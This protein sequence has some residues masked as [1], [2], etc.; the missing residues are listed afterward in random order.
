M[1]LL[2]VRHGESEANAAGVVA[3]GGK[4]A[5]S[6][7]GIEQAQKTGE[8]LV[9]HDIKVIA[10]SPYLRAQQTA[11]IIAGEIGIG[12]KDIKI[13]EELRERD[14]GETEGKPKQHD[15]E[16]YFE[17]DT[18]EGIEPRQ[19]VLDRMV[20]ALQ[21]IS[22]LEPQRGKILVVGHAVSGFYFIQAAKGNVKVKD[23]EDYSHLSNADFEVIETNEN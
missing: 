3:D 12:I 5:L 4:P 2:F 11:E 13:I 22:Q 19:V 17:T 6:Q 21:K 14:L 16:W 9:N 20:I 15:N 18:E 8:E 23:M 10:C 7:K 1:K